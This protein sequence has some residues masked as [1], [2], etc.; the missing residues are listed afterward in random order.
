MCRLPRLAALGTT[1]AIA[2]L[3]CTASVRAADMQSERLVYNIMVGGLQVGNTM[4]GLNQTPAGYSTEMKVAASGVGKWVRNFRSDMKGEGRFGDGATRPVPAAFTRQWTNG[5]IAGDMTMTFDASTGEAAVQ[6]RYFNPETDA[7]I[8]HDQL[9]WNEPGEKPRPPVPP[10]MRKDVLDPMTAFIAARGQLMA[11]GLSGNKP[12]TF[13]V[14][15]YDGRRRYDIVGRAEAARTVEI[16]GVQRSVIPV[17]AKIE[18][19]HGFDRKAQ[20]RMKE[21]EG[22]FLFSNDERFIP[23]QLV[24]ANDLVSGV[25]NLT[26]DCSI[27]PAPCDTFGQEKAS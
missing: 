25:M 26:T 23:L 8:A 13:R 3:L 16:G 17:I 1:C 22:K 4:I 14:P 9:P 15:I 27:D 6:E 10:H 21:S 5:E 18:P 12:K 2:A 20:D 19:V 24:V 7:P 11:Q